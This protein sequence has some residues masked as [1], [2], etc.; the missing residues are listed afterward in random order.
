LVTYGGSFALTFDGG[1]TLL[2][3]GGIEIVTTDAVG[4]DLL[5][6]KNYGTADTYV[7]GALLDIKD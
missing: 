6:F 2:E 1:I 7:M 4:T 5:I 3:E